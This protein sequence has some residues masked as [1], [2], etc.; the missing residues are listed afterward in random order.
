VF[1]ALGETARSYG[2]TSH[3]RN[4]RCH[5]GEKRIGL[6]IHGPKVNTAAKF[7]HI[8]G[9]RTR[10]LL[11]DRSVYLKPTHSAVSRAR[12]YTTRFLPSESGLP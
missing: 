5:N 7:C 4:G 2:H 8:L 6:D 3:P 9:A 12:R 1:G 10:D 11:P